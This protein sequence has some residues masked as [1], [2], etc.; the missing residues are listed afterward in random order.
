MN[1]GAP[2]QGLLPYEMDLFDDEESYQTQFRKMFTAISDLGRFTTSCFEQIVKE[3]D[4]FNAQIDAAESRGEEMTQKPTT[5]ISQMQ[6]MLQSLYDAWCEHFVAEMEKMREVRHYVLSEK[7]FGLDHN[8][9]KK[10]FKSTNGSHVFLELTRLNYLT[11]YPKLLEEMDALALLDPDQVS[12]DFYLMMHSLKMTKDRSFISIVDSFDISSLLDEKEDPDEQVE[13][14]RL[15]INALWEKPIM[16]Y[17]QSE[18]E[19][20]VLFLTQQ[21]NDVKTNGV[22]EYRKVFIILWLRIGQFFMEFH[23]QEVLDDEKMRNGPHNTGDPNDTY[24]C[25]PNKRFI[26]FCFFYMGELV[27]R[28]FFYDML[29]K[30][31][32]KNIPRDVKHMTA[33]AKEWITRI[34]KS[35]AEDAFEDIY[36]NN[37]PLAYAFVGDDGWYKFSETAVHSRGACIAKFRPHLHK[38]FFSEAQVTPHSVLS[39]TNDSYTSRLFILRSIHEHLKIEI[40]RLRF[41]DGVVIMNDG[42]EQSAYTLKVNKVPVLL[43]V[44]SSFWVY[45]QGRVYVCDDIYETV[46]VWFWVLHKRYN[47]HL[48][49]CDLTPFIERIVIDSGEEEMHDLNVAPGIIDLSNFEF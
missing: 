12:Q 49:D 36:A 22:E 1:Q 2:P 48:Y 17:T 7:H 31:Q 3:Q 40:P 10:K 20:L 6:G 19:M 18:V 38:R 26:G 28:F 34:T 33:R 30:N 25:A 41:I 11:H 13:Q 29:I 4:T 14:M 21:L 24:T 32:M 15:Q 5:A 35:L 37:L 23:P 45:D 44:F 8:G 16:Q 43:Q 27:R 46:A 47:N 9:K 42:I 39:T